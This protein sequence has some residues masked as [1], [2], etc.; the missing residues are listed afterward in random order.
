M[1]KGPDPATQNTYR[2]VSDLSRN[3]KTLIRL[4]GIGLIIFGLVGNLPQG[5]A[6]ASVAA[7]VFGLI[8]GGGG[9]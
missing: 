4:A 7:G 2:E 1:Q 5:W 3:V 6:V 8:A 9:G